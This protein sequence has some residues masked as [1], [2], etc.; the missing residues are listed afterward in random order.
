MVISRN[1]KIGNA[2]NVVLVYVLVFMGFLGGIFT[3]TVLFLHSKSEITKP[4]CTSTKNYH[5]LLNPPPLIVFYLNVFLVTL[6]VSSSSNSLLPAY[7][8]TCIGF[9]CYFNRGLKSLDKSCLPKV[10]TQSNYLKNHL[11]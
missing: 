8:C 1:R 5:R 11:E 4:I 9:M 2:K 6:Q 3:M 10:L 7:R